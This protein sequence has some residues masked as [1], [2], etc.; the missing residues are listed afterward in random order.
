MSTS[1]QTA[2]SFCT[3]VHA[4]AT[5][6]DAGMAEKQSASKRAQGIAHS[7]ALG[8]AL[9]SSPEPAVGVESAPAVLAP[10]SAAADAPKRKTMSTRTATPAPEAKPVEEPPS[11]PPR[12]ATPP[13]VPA[14]PEEAKRSIAPPVVDVPQLAEALE[15]EVATRLASHADVYGRLRKT[16]L[17]FESRGGEHD[18]VTAKEFAGL[19]RSEG[20]PASTPVTALML[21]RWGGEAVPNAADTPSVGL[22]SPSGKASSSMKLTTVISPRVAA[23]SLQRLRRGIIP[24]EAT[25]K[26]ADRAVA[27]WE[28]KSKRRLRS[29][30]MVSHKA[31]AAVLNGTPLA[32]RARPGEV[33]PGLPLSKLRPLCEE[34]SVVEEVAA[35]ALADA[36]ATLWA[37]SH[38]GRAVMRAEVA[39]EGKYTGKDAEAV[40]EAILSDRAQQCIQELLTDPGAAA[41]LVLE[42]CRLRGFH[43]SEGT[44]AREAVVAGVKS[45]RPSSSPAAGVVTLCLGTAGRHPVPV[46]TLT[47]DPI[48]ELRPGSFNEWLFTTAGAALQRHEAAATTTAAAV[49]KE[50]TPRAVSGMIPL[51]RLEEQLDLLSMEAGTRISS[52]A[53]M[54]RALS[55]LRRHARDGHGPATGDEEGKVELPSGLPAAA[56]TATS[57]RARGVQATQ[58]LEI[59]SPVLHAI[60]AR[61]SHGSGASKLAARLLRG[62]GALPGEE[63]AA[64][65]TGPSAREPNAAY[66]EWL[67]RKN[68]ERKRRARE[69]RAKER[70]EAEALKEKRQRGAEAYQAWVEATERGSYL[71]RRESDEGAVVEEPRPARRRLASSS[72]PEWIPVTPPKPPAPKEAPPEVTSTPPE[73]KPRRQ[74]RRPRAVDPVTSAAISAAGGR[75]A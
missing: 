56:A 40:G 41:V 33:A 69:K 32:G 66:S 15:A 72:R 74:G 47:K 68:D 19:L 26:E 70:A 42:F 13:A 45:G 48:P 64:D 49:E 36:E 63:A 7:R 62:L 34:F 12:S 14:A 50:P 44:G 46:A 5:W 71:T 57:L 4:V 59:L 60:H 6:L 21:L 18:R 16:V 43:C 27:A 29:E 67:R 22:P 61:T 39:R 35:R 30:A 31:L 10:P 9:G 17:S 24:T 53:G 58:A 8:T 37:D 52:E 51:G 38:S 11:T 28:R 23:L 65:I 25:G 20:L 3:D 54:E 73:R 55:Q 75:R 2:D 1:I